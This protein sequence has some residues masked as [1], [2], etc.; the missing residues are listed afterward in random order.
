[1][2][3]AWVRGASLLLV[4]ALA[5]ACLTPVP[6]LSPRAA[7]ELSVSLWV[8]DHGWHTAIAVRRADVDRALWPDVD[9]FPAAMFI[10]V[11]WGDRE[12]YMATPATVW[13]AIKA[14]FSTGESVLHV[15][16]F[17][18]PVAAYF[19]RSEIV[20]LHVSRSGFQA[21]TRFISEEHQRDAE[22]RPVR[23]QPGLYG[24][25]WFYAARNRYSLVNTCNTWVARA[26]QTAGFP[27][28]PSGVI[29]A[30]AVMHQVAALRSLTPSP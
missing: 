8:L 10:E 22:G 9:D 25:S 29:T 24:A 20:E 12:F 27:V 4:I 19:P 2:P 17:D 28:T 23:V 18:A 1:M 16:A 5:A 7:D 26:L 30:S 3:L 6:D 15:V 21:L 11:A 14:A 13:M